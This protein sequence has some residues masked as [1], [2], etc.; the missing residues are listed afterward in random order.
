MIV[1]NKFK[2]LLPESNL[3]A[4]SQKTGISYGRLRH[5]AEAPQTMTVEELV[6]I[7]KAYP[8]TADARMERLRRL[9]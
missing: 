5:R 9:K 4:I 3:K 6:K 2:G 1:T 7:N 8:L